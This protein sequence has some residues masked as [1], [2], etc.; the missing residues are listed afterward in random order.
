MKK[1]YILD[2]EKELLNSL[3]GIMKK[4]KNIDI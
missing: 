2:E 4:E 3:K 1:I